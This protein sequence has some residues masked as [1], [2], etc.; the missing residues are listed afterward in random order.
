METEARGSECTAAAFLATDTPHTHSMQTANYLS[1]SVVAGG[2]TQ[3]WPPWSTSLRPRAARPTATSARG[4]H[5]LPAS[6][7]SHSRTA[8]P[9]TRGS[10]SG[11]NFG[12]LARQRSPILP[13]LF[14]LIATVRAVKTNTDE[15][16]R[17]S[18][19]APGATVK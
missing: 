9:F 10:S 15:T 13:L 1:P 4:I 5:E 6:L 12:I 11:V 2:S 3:S 18:T 14:V 8:R 7:A 19:R 17:F 16:S